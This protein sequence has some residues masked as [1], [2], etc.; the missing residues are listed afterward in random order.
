MYTVEVGVAVKKGDVDKVGRCCIDL[1]AI[2][3]TETIH[4]QLL[5]V[6]PAV[7]A[8]EAAAVKAVSIDD[9]LQLVRLGVENVAH[10]ERD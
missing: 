2:V 1:A 3:G 10:E 5:A 6:V 7:A 9:V 4:C 8:V